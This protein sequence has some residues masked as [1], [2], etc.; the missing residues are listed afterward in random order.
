[1]CPTLCDPIDC[2]PPGSTI[3]GILQART[4]EWVAV[5]F[6][7]T[8]KWKWSYSVVSNSSRPCGLQPSRL[9][10]PWDF[11]GKG[12]DWDDD[13]IFILQYAN[14]VYHT[15]LRILKNPCISEINTTWSWCMIL[16]L[17]FWIQ[18]TRILLRIF[19]LYIHQWHWQTLTLRSLTWVSELSLHLP[20]TSSLSLNVK[21]HIW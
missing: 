10:C 20:V 18:F 7:S 6:S 14:V 3:P 12:T 2:S 19:Y 21:Y 9:L 1:M 15:N 5:S 4:L 13:M 17:A 11:P 8:W 16:L